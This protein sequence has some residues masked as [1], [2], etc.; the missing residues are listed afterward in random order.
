MEQVEQEREVIDARRLA[1]SRMDYDRIRSDADSWVE[2]VWHAL[3]SPVYG[4]GREK[5]E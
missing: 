1:L 3:K 5:T 4:T 2:K